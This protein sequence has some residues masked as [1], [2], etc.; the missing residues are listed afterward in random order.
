MV[1][2]DAGRGMTAEEA[3]R[4]VE[5]Y[6]GR[7]QRLQSGQRGYG[8][9]PLQQPHTPYADPRSYGP[10][11]PMQPV[12]YWRLSEEDVVRIAAAVVLRL[13][14]AAASEPKVG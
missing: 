8:Q 2:T 9:W 12:G 14:A 4:W 7:S 1:N 10:Y 5:V 6:D 3:R 13:R 11:Q